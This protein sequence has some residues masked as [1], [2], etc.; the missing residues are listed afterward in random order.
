[1]SVS[2]FSFVND[3]LFNLTLSLCAFWCHIATNR[4]VPRCHRG[5]KF[6]PLITNIGWHA[7]EFCHWFR[8]L[9]HGNRKRLPLVYMDLCSKRSGQELTVPSRFSFFVRSSFSILWISRSMMECVACSCS[10]SICSPLTFSLTC[11]E[12][13]TKWRSGSRPSP[14][15]KKNDDTHFVEFAFENLA[16]RRKC[17][18]FI[19]EKFHLRFLF[20]LTKKINLWIGCSILLFP[21]YLWQITSPPTLGPY[22]RRLLRRFRRA[23]Q[24]DVRQRWSMFLLP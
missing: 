6:R 5:P 10:L 20:L 4:A 3:P 1:M 7:E 12:D 17:F 11:D 19:F 9:R 23:R 15:H 2:S 22:S 24:N 18:V 8:R 14:P 21:L 13:T 16:P